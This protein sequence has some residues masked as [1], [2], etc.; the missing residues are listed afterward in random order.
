VLQSPANSGE[1][2][3]TFSLRSPVRPNPH[4]HIHRQAGGG[5]GSGAACARARLS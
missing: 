2:H 5:R 4:R 3:G 1:V